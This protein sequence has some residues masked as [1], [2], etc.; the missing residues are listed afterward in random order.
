MR[1]GAAV[2]VLDVR[3]AMLA[4]HA[5]AHRA[6]S[7]ATAGS[8]APRGCACAR[9]PDAAGAEE[10]RNTPVAARILALTFVQP[11]TPRHRRA[12][13]APSERRMYV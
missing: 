7:Q 13:D 2:E 6:A 8:I 3:E 1:G 10:G 12:P 11:R 9:R 5:A 4:M